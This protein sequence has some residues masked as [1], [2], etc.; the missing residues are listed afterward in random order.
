[1][2]ENITRSPDMVMTTIF[3]SSC[4]SGDSVRWPETTFS[5]YGS[6]IWN[7]S[8]PS[9]LYPIIFVSKPTKKK[10]WH[11]SETYANLAVSDCLSCTERIL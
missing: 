1:M 4:W 10:S 9:K 11:E 2:A 7:F 5:P 8:E 3:G 6:M